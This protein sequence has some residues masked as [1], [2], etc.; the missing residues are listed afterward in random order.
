MCFSRQ[1]ATFLIMGSRCTRNCR[2][3]AV[4][5]GP[6]EPPDSGEPNRVA[7][8]AT[9]MGLR[10]VVITSVTRDD[11][12]DGGAGFFAETIREIR[13]ISPGALVEVLIPDFQG[14]AAALQTVVTAHPDVLNHNLETV[15]RLYP[16][17]RPQAI[18][19]RSLELLRRAR[20]YSASIVT[21]SGLM[22]GLGEDPK[23]VPQA[24][25]DLRDTGCSMLTMGQYLQPSRAN[26]PV[27]RY[28]SPEEFDR[29][30]ETALTMGFT[31][32]ASGPLVRSSYH[33]RDL[34]QAA[35][36]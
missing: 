35:L 16:L 34:Y 10:Y 26:I 29:W 22:L 30:R 18:Y 28:L 31:R 3:C 2:F 5:Q 8:A 9:R 6:L 25:R 36:I 12:P 15:R 14:D 33:A 24:L 27:A 17:V 7:N 21:K 4:D 20:S 32:V 13:A 1:T 19:S 11:L 23:E